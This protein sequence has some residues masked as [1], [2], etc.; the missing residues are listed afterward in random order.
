MHPEIQRACFEL[1]LQEKTKLLKNLTPEK[2][3][4]LI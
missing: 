1:I 4:K 2:H 3:I